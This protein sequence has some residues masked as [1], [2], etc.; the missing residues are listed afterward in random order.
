MLRFWLILSDLNI[1]AN[2]L[3][4]AKGE[5]KR[6]IV[7]SD[8]HMANRHKS[9]GESAIWEAAGGL[10]FDLNFLIRIVSYVKR[11]TNIIA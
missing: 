9:E 8:S 4:Y 2:K 1:M 7:K 10:V 3:I 5:L 6:M 11:D